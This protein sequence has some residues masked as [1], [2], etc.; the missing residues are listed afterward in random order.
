MDMR[1]CKL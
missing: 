1:F